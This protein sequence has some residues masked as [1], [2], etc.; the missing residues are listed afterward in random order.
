MKIPH[1]HPMPIYKHITIG[2]STICFSFLEIVLGG[3]YWENKQEE[4]G[5][6]EPGIWVIPRL[7]PKHFWLP[8]VG[9]SCIKAHLVW[10]PRSEPLSG[11]SKSWE[12]ILIFIKLKESR[13]CLGEGKWVIKIFG[14]ILN[15]TT[16]IG[17]LFPNFKNIHHLRYLRT[18]SSHVYLLAND[19]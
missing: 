15:L 10:G 7:A 18:Q 8:L 17:P 16:N 1:P 14:V 6:A 2:I 5:F 13:G 19:D 9:R 11:E 3:P 12:N 4:A